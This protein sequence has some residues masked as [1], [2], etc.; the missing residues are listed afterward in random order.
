MDSTMDN[1]ITDK[2]WLN[3]M[4]FYLNIMPSK[5]CSHW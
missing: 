1:N 3:F 4:K 5:T 2:N